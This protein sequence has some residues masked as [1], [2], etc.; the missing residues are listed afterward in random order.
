LEVRT[1]PLVTYSTDGPIAV[2]TLTNPPANAYSHEMMRELDEAVLRAR[3]DDAVHVIVLTGDGDRMFCAGAD[4]AMLQRVEPSWK[5]HFCLHANET[6]LRLE[7]T[8]KLVVAALN[9][10]AVGGGLE[11]AMAADLRVAWRRT[12]PGARQLLVGLPEVTLGVLPGTGGTQRLLRLVGKAKAIELMASGENVPLERAVELGLVH[13][14]IDAADVDAFR[15]AVLDYARSFA[16][17]K[18]AAMAV[19]MI[20]RACQ[21]G[22]EVGL[23]QGLALERELQ[24]RLFTS[25]DAREGIA[26]FNEK[27]PASFTGA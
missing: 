8:P 6:L 21:T 4:I 17:P 13:R 24:Q 12:S 19:G 14:A 11:V 15:A 1:L 16:P 2:L 25:A 5:Y 7:N 9:G 27:R 20:K 26:A 3:F 23:E 10:H 18:R 22:A